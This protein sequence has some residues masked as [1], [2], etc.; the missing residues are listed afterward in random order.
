MGTGSI[1]CV[2]SPH[3][4]K[5]ISGPPGD[6]APFR[7]LQPGELFLF[8]LHA[9]LNFIVGG[10]VFAYQRLRSELNQRGAVITSKLTAID[11]RSERIVDAITE[12]TAVQALKVKLGQLEAEKESL[13][14]EREWRGG[15]A[16]S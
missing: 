9:P 8:K 11:S 12:G 16:G 1:I 5:S 7:A 14:H 6:A 10:G 4:Q 2:Q 13:Q 15:G 3:F